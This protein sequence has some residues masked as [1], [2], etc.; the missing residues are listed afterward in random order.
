MSG[1]TRTGTC[2]R[3]LAT[4][5]RG[6][7]LFFVSRIVL[8]Q[9]FGGFEYLELPHSEGYLYWYYEDQMSDNGSRVPFSAIF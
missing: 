5:P 8:F 1:G 3:S 7:L 4:R 6:H 2:I 9:D